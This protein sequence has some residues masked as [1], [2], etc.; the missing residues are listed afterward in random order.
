MK[1]AYSIFSNQGG[2]QINEDYADCAVSKDAYCFVLCDG[3]GGHGGGDAGADWDTV[4][5]RGGKGA[6]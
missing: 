2:R 5:G 4:G 3:L 6:I 1:T